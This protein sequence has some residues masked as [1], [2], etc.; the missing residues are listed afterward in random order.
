[1]LSLLGFIK[2]NAPRFKI[3]LVGSRFSDRLNLFLILIFQ[4]IPNRIK[5]PG[6]VFDRKLCDL[7]LRLY[8]VIAIRV[9]AVK[10]NR[11]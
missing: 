11:P 6:S 1:M 9:G 4:S 3:V 8:S 5:R 2:R 7:T 10:Y